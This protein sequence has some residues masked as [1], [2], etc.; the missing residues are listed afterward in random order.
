MLNKFYLLSIP[1]S[2]F[3][4]DNIEL[5]GI[6]TKIKS[7]LNVYFTLFQFL[8]EGTLVKSYKME[9]PFFYFLL[10]DINFY[11]SYHFI[12]FQNFIQHLSE[13]KIS[14]T[15][16]RFFLNGFTKPTHPLNAKQLKPA[17]RDEHFLLMLFPME[18]I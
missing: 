12:A 4:T 16:F 8:I 14:I 1:H 13:K 15:N 6:P 3:L 17:K 5:E 9:L 18:V 2:L 11:S 7:N 10:F